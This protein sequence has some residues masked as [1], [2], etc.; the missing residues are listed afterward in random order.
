M[1]LITRINA[2]ATR[3]ANEF[4]SIRNEYVSIAG[5]ED[6][7]P[8]RI[9]QESSYI[10]NWD[11]AI[12]SGF[13]ISSGALHEPPGGDYYYAGVVVR[14]SEDFVVQVAYPLNDDTPDGVTTRTEYKRVMQQNGWSSWEKV[15][16]HH[17]S[18]ITNGV[19]DPARL[20]AA[21]TTAIGA[22][23][24]AT[25]AETTTGT[26]TVR[27]VTPAGVKAVADTKAAASHNH[28]ATDIN[29]G[30]LNNARLPARLREVQTDLLIDLNSATASGWYVS[31]QNP[32][33]APAAG[34]YVWGLNV[35]AHFAG[36]IVQ[37]AT[38]LNGGSSFN[39][40]RFRRIMT[41]NIW[42]AWFQIEDS[43][44]V[45]Q[46]SFAPIYHT[47]ANHPEEWTK[48][49][50][51]VAA[52]SNVASL[53]GL[54]TIDGVTLVAGD[55]VLLTGQ[56]SAAANGIYV[57]AAGAW[58]RATDANTTSK[59]TGA[60]VSVAEGTTAGGLVFRNGFKQGNTLGT[61]A[62]PWEVMLSAPFGGALPVAIGGTGAT[63]AYGIRW[64]AGAL[65]SAS[66]LL[67]AISAG[68]WTDVPG[69]NALMNRNGFQISFREVS[70][71][72]GVN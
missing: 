65:G 14:V 64:N 52:T 1:S 36:Y 58:A 2:L 33:N 5:I 47:H 48:Q 22:V 23:E 16:I 20:P 72:E 29:S 38:L 15:S 17:A 46:S 45:M 12:T 55:R 21:T 59:I 42:A 34:A 50:V 63:D 35:D 69:L 10:S 70:S 67:P 60:V 32:S 6:Y 13:Y 51:R 68:V 31:D 18:D 3:V 61:T 40:F 19:L 30:T 9:S 49:E 11:N 71:G 4:N 41:N 62:M 28:A 7:L 53:S 39:Q 43:L 66:T 37:T 8:D 27:A 56:T 57:A 24:L 25:N 26:D 54:L 44:Y